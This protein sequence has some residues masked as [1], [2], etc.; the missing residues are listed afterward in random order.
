MFQGS[1]KSVSRKFQECVKE[2][3]RKVQGCLINVKRVFKVGK[4]LLSSFKGG[5]RIFERSLKC[6]SGKGVSRNFSRTFNFQ[7]VSKSFKGI[8][9]MFQ[10]YFKED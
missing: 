7:S 3:S 1:F 10:A 8:S 5:S 4:C 9:Q 2:V 6:V